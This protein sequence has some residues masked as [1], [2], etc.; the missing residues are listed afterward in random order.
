M[1]QSYYKKIWDAKVKDKPEG[2]IKLTSEAILNAL[3]VSSYSFSFN[4]ILCILEFKESILILVGI[5][6]IAKF[7]ARQR[8]II[9]QY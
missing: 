3:Q 5:K 4:T 9:A 6:T 7:A 2:L 8:Y 1:Y